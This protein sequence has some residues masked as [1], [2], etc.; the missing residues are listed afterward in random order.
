MLKITDMNT[1]IASAAEQQRQVAEDVSQ[2]INRISEATT[3]SSAGSNQVVSASRE[4]SLLAEQLSQKVS[5]FQLTS[6][7]EPSKGLR[8]I[9]R[10][11]TSDARLRV[12]PRLSLA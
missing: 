10:S 11:L 6:F 9:P 7:R 1:Q 12:V 8:E 4:L 2:N 5:Y 3:A